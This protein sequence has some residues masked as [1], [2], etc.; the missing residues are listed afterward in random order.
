MEHYYFIHISSGES[1]IV[2]RLHVSLRVSFY[3]VIILLFTAIGRRQNAKVIF[4]NAI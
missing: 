4:K 3:V 1:D 2:K